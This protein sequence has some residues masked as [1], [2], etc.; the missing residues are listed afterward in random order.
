MNE[1][2]R[3]LLQSCSHGYKHEENPVQNMRRIMFN[4]AGKS[5]YVLFLILTFTVC[6]PVCAEETKS[7][8]TLYRDK[9][10][11][12]FRTEYNTVD[13]SNL[14]YFLLK[15]DDDEIPELIVKPLMNGVPA[16]IVTFYDNQLSEYRIGGISSC[17]TG[18]GLFFYRYA[19]RSN[20]TEMVYMLQHGEFSLLLDGECSEDDGVYTWNGEAVSREEY[21]NR[22]EELYPAEEAEDSFQEMVQREILSA[23]EDYETGSIESGGSY[24]DHVIDFHGDRAAEQAIRAYIRKEEGDILLSDLMEIDTLYLSADGDQKIHDISFVS[25]LTKLRYLY[26]F[27]NDVSDLSPLSGLTGLT[28]LSV[29][30]NP[31]RDLSQL[32]SL[33][34]LRFLSLNYMDIQDYSPLSSLTNLSSLYVQGNHLTD[35]L[36]SDLI[37]S[38]KDLP[39]LTGFAAGEN[40]FTNYELLGRL[41]QLTR[42][43]MRTSDL[44]DEGL[45]RLTEIFSAFP[46]LQELD[47]S[48]NSITDVSC[49]ASLAGL[50]VLDVRGNPVSDFSSLAG[51]SIVT[52]KSDS[53]NGTPAA[54]DTNVYE[55]PDSMGSGTADEIASLAE[56]L[57]LHKVENSEYP[58]GYYE[59]IGIRMGS[60]LHAGTNTPCL[61]VENNGNTR[62]GF[63]GIRIGMTRDEALETVKSF[64]SN[65]EYRQGYLY[66]GGEG[67]GLKVHFGPDGLLKSFLYELYYTG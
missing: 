48:D 60:N 67:P 13:T 9:L 7:W 65:A 63:E 42:L 12:L 14:R 41:N 64:S 57:W 35:A 8:K 32:S 30:G 11:E 22:L 38:I 15:V 37:D 53:F 46:D 4:R 56:T 24:D 21:L 36:L 45:S 50:Q 31:V 18:S 47:V 39:N 54:G 10:Y 20:S 58:D 6:I 34:E 16:F 61:L 59:G 26:L 52:I 29:S 17:I 27:Q 19:Y 2:F 23:I 51:S 44:D 3:H 43:G 62:L 55:A 66:F 25:E 49:L 1:I 5:L 33:S 40:L 28:S